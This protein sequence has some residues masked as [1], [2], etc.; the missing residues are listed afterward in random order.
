MDRLQGV[1]LGLVK[2]MHK[3]RMHC[4]Q[5]MHITRGKAERKHPNARRPGHTLAPFR[6]SFLSMVSRHR[7]STSEYNSHSCLLTVS[8]EVLYVVS[9]G[10]SC[11]LCVVVSWLE[12]GLEEAR[13]FVRGIWCGRG[14]GTDES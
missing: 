14:W 9:V 1:T 2:A 5:D 8:C 12:E 11:F 13:I 7:V 10:G 4:F 3:T 6:P